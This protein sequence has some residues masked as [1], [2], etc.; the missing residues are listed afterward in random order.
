MWGTTTATRVF[1]FILKEFIFKD[2]VTT[3]F[4]FFIPIIALAPDVPTLLFMFYFKYLEQLH[5]FQVK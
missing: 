1:W 3:Q 5:I 4:F 2:S